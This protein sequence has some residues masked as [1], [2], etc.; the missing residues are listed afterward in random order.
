MT[1]VALDPYTNHGHDGII[2]NGKI[3]NDETIKIL[4]KQ[5]IL[6]SKVAVI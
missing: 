1:D 4:I 6:Q 5:A 2:S 3:N